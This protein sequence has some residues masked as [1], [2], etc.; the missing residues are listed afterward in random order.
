MPP[1]IAA[2]PVS[3]TVYAGQP[4]S[5]SVTALGGSPYTYQWKH[6]GTNL[7]A[8]TKR[9]LTIPSA[10]PSDAGA[11]SVTVNNSVGPAVNSQVAGLTVLP[12]PY[13]DVSGAGVIGD[14]TLTTVA[15]VARVPVDG[16]N[17]T[18][19]GGGGVVY[20]SLTSPA[21]TVPATHVNG[22]T[23]TLKFKH[24]YNLELGWDGGAVYVSKNGAPATYVDG[25]AFS[26]NGY[27]GPVPGSSV[28]TRGRVCST[29]YPQVGAQG[30]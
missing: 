3:Q 7:P 24:R 12:P 10:Q 25:T 20:S 27:A 29:T 14:T 11:Y 8:A 22:G 18:A 21:F 9:V 23:V 6:A 13:V 1:Q 28:F 17:W 4:A 15:G 26:A 5:F 2:E 19:A 30:L 16:V